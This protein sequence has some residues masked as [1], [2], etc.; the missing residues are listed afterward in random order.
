M[1]KK[2]DLKKFRRKWFSKALIMMIPSFLVDIII[3][4]R[5][6]TMNP[7]II[8]KN[9][10]LDLKLI[11]M[12]FIFN[13]II[14]KSEFLIW[15]FILR[16]NR[17]RSEV[18]IQDQKVIYRKRRIVGYSL[19][20]GYKI[21]AEY[22]II[23]VISIK[24]KGNGAIL[25]RGKNQVIYYLIDGKTVHSNRKI[26]KCKI[27]GYFSDMEKTYEKLISIKEKS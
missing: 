13:A 10:N 18:R 6:F 9:G 14:L 25:I 15:Y 12:L 17:V 4:I 19:Y 20:Y 21:F 24:K 16:Y 2:L 22:H 5:I 11:C 8:D 23:D 27:P 3:F 26:T 7:V 1:V